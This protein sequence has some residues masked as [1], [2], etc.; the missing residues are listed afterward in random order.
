MI[1]GGGE[2]V[3]IKVFL[4]HK[5]EAALYKNEE[6]GTYTVF[7]HTKLEDTIPKETNKKLKLFD[8]EHI[9]FSI[10]FIG[11]GGSGEKENKGERQLKSW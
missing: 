6:F 5:L 8:K 4:K 9:R 2:V 10:L 1:R 7:I 3:L 11:W